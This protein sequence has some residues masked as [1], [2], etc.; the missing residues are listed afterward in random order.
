MKVKV[1]AL[2]YELVNPTDVEEH[3]ILDGAFGK[4][5]RQTLKIYIKQS[6]P[7][8]L[9]RSVLLHEV[10]HAIHEQY[11]NSVDGPSCEEDIVLMMEHGIMA[12]FVDNPHLVEFLFPKEK[13]NAGSKPKTS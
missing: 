4:C 6:L 13:K 1:G 3:T 7:D 2:T 10:L 5:N 9:Y 11:M 8:D 12:V